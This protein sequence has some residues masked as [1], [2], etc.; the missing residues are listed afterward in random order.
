MTQMLSI[1]FGILTL[2]CFGQN[3]VYKFSGNENDSNLTYRPQMHSWDLSRIGRYDK[4]LASWDKDSKSNNKLSEQDS[5]NFLKFYPVNAIEFI[6][7]KAD[8]FRVIM[9]NEA[10]HSNLHRN[11][12]K[13]LLKELYKGHL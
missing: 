12:T 2:N 7:K 8:S 4:A 13:K 3:D 11:F 1:L 9:V 6:S 5:L 10:H